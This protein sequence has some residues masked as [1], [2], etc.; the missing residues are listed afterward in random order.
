MY[1]KLCVNARSMPFWCVGNPLGDPVGGPVQPKLDSLEVAQII[2]DAKTEGLIEMTSYHD[3]DLVPWDP[4]HPEDDLDPKSAAYAKL[5]AIR[6]I[7]RKAGVK[8]FTFSST[9]SSTVETAWLFLQNG[10]K[11]EGMAEI[12]GTCQ[13]FMSDEYERVPAYVFS[14]T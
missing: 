11:L 13:A 2:A 8:M 5:V 3:D 4:A 7:L 1:N 14:I 12:N 6:K 9:W 10:C